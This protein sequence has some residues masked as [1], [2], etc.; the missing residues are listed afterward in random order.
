MLI[1]DFFIKKPYGIERKSFR[2][3]QIRGIFT[4]S[5]Y[6]VQ[7]LSIEIYYYFTGIK[8]PFNRGFELKWVKGK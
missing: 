2:I 1:I 4:Q 8:G 5:V 3:D 6:P 7:F